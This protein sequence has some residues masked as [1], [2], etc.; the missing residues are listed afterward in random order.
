MDT[1][2]Q[3]SP[4]A[5]RVQASLTSGGFSCEVVELP[6]ST[7]TAKEAA[8]AIGCTL[9]QIAKSLL[10][11]TQKTRRP[12]LVIASGA[13]RVNEGALGEI[14]GESVAKADAHFVQE[15][16]GFVIGG[17]PPLAHSEPLITVLDEDLRQYPEIWAAGGSPTAVFRLT[18]TELEAM[19]SG[20][21]VR[22]RT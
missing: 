15:K 11:V 3:L 21:W 14:L 7:H 8:E 6:T 4:G 18:P 20:R 17:V 5:Q 22:T 2:K 19:S 12:V 1:R 10:F 13:N 9:A 16:T